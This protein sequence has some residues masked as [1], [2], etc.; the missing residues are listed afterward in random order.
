MRYT[1]IFEG[2]I[3]GRETVLTAA[4]SLCLNARYDILS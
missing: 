4:T 1:L 3:A 2:A